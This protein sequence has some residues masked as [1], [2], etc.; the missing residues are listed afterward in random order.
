MRYLARIMAIL[1]I[2]L[3]SLLAVRPVLTFPPL[4]SS[5]HG[6]VKVN[7]TNVPEGTLIKAYIEGRTCAEKQTQTIQD[8]SMYTLNIPGDDPTT[9]VVE[10]G[11]DGDTIVFTIGGVEADQTGLWKS[12]T[13]IALNLSASTS[14]TLISPQNTHTPMPTQNSIMSVEQK[15][16]TATTEALT[17]PIAGVS[18][19]ASPLPTA[20]IQT[21]QPLPTATKPEDDQTNFS[22]TIVIIGIIVVVCILLYFFWLIKVRKPKEME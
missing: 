19:L 8:D 11:R 4:P 2:S 6:T 7:A 12:G 21:S 9:T 17:S 20:L 13:S 3:I 18:T 1:G 10:G 5:F 14:V 15:S 22:Q 16:A